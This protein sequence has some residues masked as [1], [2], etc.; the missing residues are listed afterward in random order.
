[1]LQA[2]EA[3]SG[4]LQRSPPVYRSLGVYPGG[5]VAYRIHPPAS[6]SAAQGLS[7]LPTGCHMLSE[8]PEGR[9][10]AWRKI[11]ER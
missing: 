7:S 4:N 9:G 6:P 5:A 1:M 3:W 10:G 8:Y 2:S 11:W